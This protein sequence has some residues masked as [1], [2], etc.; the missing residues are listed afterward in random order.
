[1]ISTKKEV[2]YLLLWREMNGFKFCNSFE[3][4]GKLTGVMIETIKTIVLS[5][6]YF[7]LISVE[8]NECQLINR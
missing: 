2:L 5:N 7:R 1:M 4:K 6:E 8:H 3:F